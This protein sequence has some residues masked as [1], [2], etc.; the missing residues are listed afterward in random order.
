MGITRSTLLNSA[1]AAMLALPLWVGA[2][3]AQETQG[4]EGQGTDQAQQTQPSGDAGQAS[5]SDSL[6]ARLG[7][8]EIQSSDVLTAIGQLPP[9][10]NRLPPWSQSCKMRAYGARC[11]S[12]VVS[13]RPIQLS[14]K[15][16][17][18]FC[19]RQPRIGM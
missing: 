12:M 11:T 3:L 7:D 18:R 14:F 5:G 9:T 13:L 6:V 2:G 15:L 10:L 17:A 16:V 8:A 19:I 1:A 4:T